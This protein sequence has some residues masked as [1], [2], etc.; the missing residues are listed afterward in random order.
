V[1]HVAVLAWLQ[2]HPVDGVLPVRG[3]VG[4]AGVFIEAEVVAHHA[5]GDKFGLPGGVVG[6]R[7]DA[8]PSVLADQVVHPVPALGRLGQQVLVIQRLQPPARG[9]E[10]GA[11]Q[12]G[13][14]V[15]V[16]VGAGVQP[17]PP[18]Q[19]LLIFGQVRVRQ[20]ER[21]GQLGPAVS[22]PGEPPG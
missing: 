18:E 12:R 13:G 14:R 4:D 8:H 17:Q 10:T 7:V 1:P 9:R 22:A 3:D 2:R 15:A 11:V 20:V 16:D 6:I 5:A 21:G 19:P